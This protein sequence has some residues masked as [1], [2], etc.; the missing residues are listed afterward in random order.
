MGQACTV[1]DGSIRE[2]V[3]LGVT[4][5]IG[6]SDSDALAAMRDAECYDAFFDRSKFPEGWNTNIADCAGSISGGEQQRLVIA[7]ALLRPS[8]VLLLD[9]AFSALDKSNRDNIKANM[10]QRMRG[11]SIIAI[12]HNMDHSFGE[13]CSAVVKVESGR[14]TQNRNEC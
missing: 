11:R 7:R 14:A 1:I 8:R 13:R 2:N 10:L 6:T 9:E 12:S 3:L 4:D 5:R